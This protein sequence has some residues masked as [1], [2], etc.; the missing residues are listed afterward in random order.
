MSSSATRRYMR[1]M[2]KDI[3]KG[4]KKANNQFNIPTEKDVEDYIQTKVK[5]IRNAT[6]K[7]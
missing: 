3:A 6:T 5:E 1:K 2:K 4:H 7:S